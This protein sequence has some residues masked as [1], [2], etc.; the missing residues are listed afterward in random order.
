MLKKKDL[1]TVW[2]M[3]FSK[4]SIQ[5]FNFLHFTLLFPMKIKKEESFTTQFT[6][7]CKSK[8]TN[9]QFRIDLFCQARNKRK[10]CAMQKCY[11]SPVHWSS[12]SIK[13][14]SSLEGTFVKKSSANPFVQL[15]P[16]LCR[17]CPFIY[18][19]YA[20]ELQKLKLLISHSGILISHSGILV[21][22]CQLI[23]QTLVI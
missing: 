21:A 22:I 10:K 4:I 15:F 9:L 5:K 6:L 14:L 8:V 13:Y 11:A 20:N 18:S 16:S 17:A 3:S 1:Q 12:L 23:I 2:K 19:V 7:K